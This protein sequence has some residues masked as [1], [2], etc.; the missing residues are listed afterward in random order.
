MI[1]RPPRSTRTDTLFPYTTLF[2][3]P[4]L[5]IIGY[6]DLD[7]VIGAINAQPKPLALYI[8]SKNESNIQRMLNRTSAGGTCINHVV[9]PF[10]QGNLP[11]VGVN[12][13]VIGSAHGDFGFKAFSHERA[14]VRTRFNLPT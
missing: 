7:Q 9:M 14:V 6:R 11:F 8:W 2:R 3:S 12:H 1:R 10:A 5:P 13:S 4:L